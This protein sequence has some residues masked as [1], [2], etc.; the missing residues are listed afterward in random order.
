MTSGL[1]GTIVSMDP[2]AQKMKLMVG[3]YFEACAKLDPHAIAACFTPGAVHY[4]PHLAPLHGGATIGNALVG[5]LRGRGGRY[6]IDRV[7]TNVEQ[8]SAAVEWTRTF[9]QGD[10]VLRGLECCEFDPASILIRE[11]RGYYAA[12]PNP[13]IARH[14]LLGF[15]YPGRGYTLTAAGA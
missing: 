5:D 13:G 7:I 6:F 1:G 10:R 3:A 9:H 11:I 8:C 2:I 4:L 12:A 15:D 14:E